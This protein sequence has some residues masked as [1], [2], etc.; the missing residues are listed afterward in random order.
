MIELSEMP[1]SVRVVPFRLAPSEFIT[2]RDGTIS[3]FAAPIAFWAGALIAFSETELASP[4]D[5]EHDHIEQGHEA[6]TGRAVH[7]V[8][9]AIREISHSI[10]AVPII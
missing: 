6:F 1:L 2:I 5:R 8:N 9:K 7:A 10:A 4:L 3:C